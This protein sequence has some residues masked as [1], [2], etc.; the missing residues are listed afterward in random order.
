MAPKSLPRGSH[1]VR[2]TDLVDLAEFQTLMA[3]TYGE[4]DRRRGVEATVAWL[5][6]ELGELARAIR[7]GSRA[8]QE[9]ELG[10]AQAWL[11]SLAAQLDLSLD[12]A[13]SR[14]ADGCPGCGEIPC[15]CGRD[16]GT[17]S[18]GGAR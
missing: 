13:A 7:K 9:H 16:E 1:E 5:T 3:R 2:L 11:A 8:Q 4:R 6:E 14:Y 10:D 12:E 18:H 15:A 17:L